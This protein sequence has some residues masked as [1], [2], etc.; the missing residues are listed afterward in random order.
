MKNPW[1]IVGVLAVILFGGSFW[2]ASESAERNNEGV[3]IK[4]QIKGNSEA[5]VS[6]VKYS[7]FSCPACRDASFVVADV[8]EEYG[9]S[10]AFEYRHFP[11]ISPASTRAAVAAEAAGQQGKFYE[12]HDLL[13]ENQTVWRNSPNPAVLF[14]DYAETLELDMD[15]FRRHLNSTLLRE[16]TMSDMA[17]GRERGVTGTPT[18]FLNGERLVFQSYEEFNNQIVAAITGEVLQEEPTVPDDSAEIRFGI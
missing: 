6:L 15:T 12:Y 2:Y 13:F 4:P 10:V 11:F 14:L 18:F 16:H 9:E 8:M 5:E 17:E 3:E 1:V 7:D